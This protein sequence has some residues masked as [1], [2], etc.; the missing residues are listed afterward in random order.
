MPTR[1]ASTSLGSIGLSD[2]ALIADRTSG[3]LRSLTEALT[4]TPNLQRLTLSNPFLFGTISDEYRWFPVLEFF[5]L[6]PPLSA[7]QYLRLDPSRIIGTPHPELLQT[8]RAILPK[9]PQLLV[10]EIVHD[11]DQQERKAL[12]DN[13]YD[14][15]HPSVLVRLVIR[16]D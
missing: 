3:S 8:L 6:C 16:D 5:K 2:L 13:I 11:A 14:G 1:Q 4:D 15:F 9:F 7:L 12:M 10:I